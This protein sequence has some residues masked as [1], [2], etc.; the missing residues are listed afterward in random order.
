MDIVDCSP[1]HSQLGAPNL[2]VRAIDKRTAL[3]EIESAG[4]L[5][6]GRSAFLDGKEG[7]GR[8]QRYRHLPILICCNLDSYSAFHGGSLG[9]GLWDGC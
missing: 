9:D 4:V 7:T 2:F 8:L 1:Y 3:P 6:V 5:S